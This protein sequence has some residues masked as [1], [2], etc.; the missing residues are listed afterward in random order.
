MVGGKLIFCVMQRVPGA[1]NNLTVQ[2]SLAVCH[3]FPEFEQLY[4]Q[5]ADRPPRP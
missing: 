4:A 1:G 3:S 5:A 2:T